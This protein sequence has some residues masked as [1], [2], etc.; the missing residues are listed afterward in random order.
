[1]KQ[2][3]YGL[4]F[5]IIDHQS[6]LPFPEDVF[7]EMIEIATNS[8]SFSFND[9]MHQMHGISMGSPLGPI[10]ANI[11]VGFHE[12]QLLEK[13]PKPYIYLR[14]VDDTC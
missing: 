7:V 12:R 3:L 4:T 6:V 11:F 1:M 8:V 5:Y 9:V 14:Y 13:F 10:L 2:F